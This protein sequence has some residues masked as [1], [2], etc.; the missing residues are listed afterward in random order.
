MGRNVAT[1]QKHKIV[2]FNKFI[3]LMVSA[4][5]PKSS[6]LWQKNNNFVA[7]ENF[8]DVEVPE[9][10]DDNSDNDDDELSFSLYNPEILRARIIRHLPTKQESLYG[11]EL[12]LTCLTTVLFPVDIEWFC[13]GDVI[14]PTL[15]G[16]VYFTEDRRQL[17]VTYLTYEDEGTIEVIAHNRFGSERSRCSLRIKKRTRAAADSVL[18]KPRRNC[19]TSYD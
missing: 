5:D 9:N 10:E 8:V 7:D 6:I 19:L 15:D 4:C 12:V 18:A 11:T 13:N 1:T 14:E 16:R 17:V 2:T 3:S